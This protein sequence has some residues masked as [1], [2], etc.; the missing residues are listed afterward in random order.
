MLPRFVKGE[1]CQKN[2]IAY[3]RKLID[4]PRKGNMAYLTI[5]KAFDMMPH[6]KLLIQWGMIGLGRRRVCGGLAKEGKN[7]SDD[8]GMIKLEEVDSLCSCSRN[9]LGSDSA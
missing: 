9:N 8:V 6:G 3:Q 5:S 7:T 1:L 2:L 4:F